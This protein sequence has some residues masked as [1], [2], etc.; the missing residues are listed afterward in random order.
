MNPLFANLSGRT[1]LR[2]AGADR[3]RFLN[4]QVTGNI[5]R[6]STGGTLYACIL[7]AKGKLCGDLFITAEP[8][9]LR[10]DADPVLRESLSVRL[11]RYIISDDVTLEDLTDETGLLHM[12][13][14]GD[15]IELPGLAKSASNRLGVPGFDFYGPRTLV[16]QACAGL[17]LT[18]PEVLEALRVENGVPKWG[19]E[20]SEEIL[21]AEAGLDA[22][23]IDFH[24]GCYVG[25]EIVSRLKSVGH[26]NKRLHRFSSVAPLEPG[27]SLLG[28]DGQEVGRLT[29]VAYS[30]A[31][32]RHVA[33]GYLKRGF[34]GPVVH[35]SSG[36][37]DVQV[38]ELTP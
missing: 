35:T 25:Q 6:L 18:S 15:S 13:P 19:A 11:E 38:H 21:P 26:V 20:L 31:L 33:L 14:E 32:A 5:S 34:A 2:L 12:I 7:T 8:D 27:T 4:G 1:T 29:S 23:A 30:F 22:R 10:I 37:A 9:A 36:G 24:K 3:V 17:N 16:D 28:P